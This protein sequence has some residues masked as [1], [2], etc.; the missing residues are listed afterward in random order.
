MSELRNQ[1]MWNR[2]ISIVEEQA[3]A[4]VR[5]AFSTS[6]REAGDLSAG[7]YDAEGR[8]IAQ[9]VTGTPGHVNTMAAAVVNF[10]EDIGPHRIYEGDSYIT[11]DPWK[12]TGHLHDFTVVNPVFRNGTLVAFFACTAH[13]VDVGGRGYGPD[14]TEVY[15]EGL[16]VPIMKFAERGVVNEDLLNIVRH[17]VREAGQVVGDLYSLSGCND[18]GIRRLHAMLD[19]FDLD[20]LADL[21]AF[22]FDRTDT[23]TRERIRTLPVG[24]YSNEMRVDGYNDSVDLAV[25][26]T[27]TDDGAHAYFSY[28]M[29]VALA[30]EM[31]SNHASLA[32]FTVSAPEGCIL[33]A[34]HPEPVAVRHVIGHFVTDL[35]LGAIAGALPDIVPAEGAGALWNFQVSARAT[36]PMSGLPPREILM[37]NSGGTGARPT[38]D[39][40]NATAFPSGVRTMPAEATEQAGPI[41]VWRKELRPDSGGAGRMRGG[42]GQVIELGPTEGYEFAF[43]CMFDRVQNPAR[44]RHGGGDGATGRVY[45]DDG[46]PFN[47]KGKQMVPEGRTLILELPGGGGFGDE[48]ER[49]PEDVIRDHRQG[50]VS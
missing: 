19:E 27:V 13:V 22:V 17:N 24:T 31:P 25:T 43:S 15:E 26:L 7:V 10:I 14:A 32:V 3:L 40:L 47:A 48:G 11:N 33:N 39:G 20:D 5:T 9:A 49:D 30:P 6:V 42:L 16:F 1:V 8:M 37:F 28:A 35:C 45:L 46:T 44:G 4:L 29:L 12:G 36:D 2:L 41:V 50:Y 34:K 23:A 38:L 21:A 18:T